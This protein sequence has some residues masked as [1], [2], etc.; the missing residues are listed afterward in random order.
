MRK[1]SLTIAAIILAALHAV[2]PEKVDVITVA[3]LGASLLPWI[4]PMFK[5]ID[6]PG[7]GRIDFSKLEEAEKR[8][9]DS[10]LVSPEE[11][12]KPMQKH[13]YA[14]QAVSEDDPNLALS[15]LRAE[16][17]SQLRELAEYRGIDT[18]GLGTPS[19]MELLE[20]LGTLSRTEAQAIRE[21]L[22]LLDKAAHGV[23]VDRSALVWAMDFGPRVLRAF[24]NRVVPS[25]IPDLIEGW[26]RRDGAMVADIGMNLSKSFVNSPESFLSS[27]SRHPDEFET[28]IKDMG[29]HTFT[30]FDSRSELEDKLYL[31]QHEKLKMLMIDAAESC[32]QTQYGSLA[33]KIKDTVSNIKIDSTW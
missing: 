5:S 23:S 16:I 2:F 6:I 32:M 18:Q 29:H 27:M 22:P 3:L 4:Y 11:D 21:L 12:T 31:A 17:E 10:G 25:T 9:M 8:I 26:K 28:W 13:S 14:F 15:A 20:K 19:V 30:I 33:S 24:E 1:I 7:V